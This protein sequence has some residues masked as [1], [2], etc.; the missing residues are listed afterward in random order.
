M[1][2]GGEEEA[3]YGL[4]LSE[5]VGKLSPTAVA[6]SLPARIRAELSKDE[7]VDSVDVDVAIAIEGPAASFNIAIRV[8]TGE[9]PFTLQLLV[10]AV[11]VALLGIES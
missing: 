5:L 4:D 9:G 1:L 7:R 6:A 10:S 2:R 3:N 11:D 8:V